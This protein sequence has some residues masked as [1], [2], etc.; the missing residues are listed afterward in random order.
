MAGAA[1]AGV[2]ALALAALYLRG[3]AIVFEMDS[4]YPGVLAGFHAPERHEGL[5]FAWTSEQA[6]IDVPDVDRRA[7]W[8]CAISAINWRP[9]SAG[10]AEVRVQADGEAAADFRVT[11]PV[12]TLR[13]IVPRSPGR[14]SLRVSIV[15]SPAFRP[16]G[17][18]PRALGLVVDRIRC[19]PDGSL[20]LPAM[21][22]LGRSA[23]G[24][25]IMGAAA[26]ASGLSLPAAVAFAGLTALFQAVPL[27]AGSG[28]YLAASH[29][30]W[31]TA[32]I[33]AALLMGSAAIA[34]L[35]RRGRPVSAEARL[36]IAVSAAAAY[37]QLLFL[38]HPDKDIVD[39]LFH[40]HR[41]QWVLDGR[42]Y[43]TQLSTSATPFPYA[44]GLYLVAA[45]FAWLTGDHVT[46]L[47]FVVCVSSAAA[48]ALLYPMIVRAW[49]DRVAGVAAVVLYN[50]V[51]V[52]YIVTG[53]ANLTNAFG[54]SAS[55]VAVAA[56]TLLPL[57][58]ARRLV[59]VLI[60][61]VVAALALISHVS[62]LVL[63]FAT[64]VFLVVAYRLA[65]R[66]EL[67]APGRSIAAATAVAALLA[68]ALYWGHFG[69]V[70]LAQLRSASAASGAS[71]GEGERETRPG[72]DAHA[73]VS[74][75]AELG[76]STIPLSRRAT[77]A[78]AQ[79]AANIGWPILI[80]GVVGLWRTARR[81]VA[82]R[83]VLAVAAW[84]LTAFAFLAFSVIGPTGVKYQQDAWEFIGRV[85]HAASPAAVV[86][87]A[88][89]LAW[90]WRWN[91][92]GRLL[93]TALFAW[94]FL[95]G[96]GVLYGWIA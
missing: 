93:G 79:T 8:A 6:V 42:F 14:S 12:E 1:G 73:A 44:I 81:R 57:Q 53:H 22:A 90:L 94:A 69:E 92:G 75:P 80:L 34:Q 10:P 45:P 54:Q 32:A 85:E 24:A 25:G 74:E 5:T 68:I 89:G 48:G 55:L 26:G 60:L 9:V 58:G 46:L 41:L 70:Y 19:E 43:F 39:A 11:A 28:P 7:S 4:A 20:A 91:R 82:D 88:A 72:E 63:L 40:A 78:L 3:P 96:A 87:A 50:L 17:G 31:R 77:A 30:A 13:F 62:T 35:L 66:P 18:D 38:L 2:A 47:R 76:R 61:A 83:L 84:L 49:E 21:A 56:A 64:L 23:A 27:A 59:H 52:A 37:L 67:R 51:P 15:V 71:V 95:A 16:G 65:G 36:A 29:P 33:M 86:L